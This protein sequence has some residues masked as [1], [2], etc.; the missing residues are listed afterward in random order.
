[1]TVEQVKTSKGYRQEIIA[2][3]AVRMSKEEIN[4]CEDLTSTVRDA[5]LKV[6]P[7]SDNENLGFGRT[8]NT[9]FGSTYHVHIYKENK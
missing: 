8:S 5:V 3:Y 1:M 9:Y 4:N 2:T 6:R 7:L